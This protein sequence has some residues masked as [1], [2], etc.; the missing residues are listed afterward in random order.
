MEK[1][2]RP[3]IVRPL[4][5]NGERVRDPS[6]TSGVLHFFAM[7]FITLLCTWVLLIFLEPDSIW[8]NH[9][10]LAT[11]KAGDLFAVA[12]SHFANVGLGMGE[13]VANHSF[14]DLSQVSKLLLLCVMLLGRLDFFA[15]LLLFSPAFWKR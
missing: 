6:I 10:Y 11:G 12:I 15:I 13:F 9:T 1:I 3:S 14:G 2:Y 8:A 5:Y 7:T 4:Y